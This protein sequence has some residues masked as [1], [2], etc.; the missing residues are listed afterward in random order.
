MRVSQPAAVPHAKRLAC[1][2]PSRR[3]SKSFNKNDTC[4]TMHM[5]C[6]TMHIPCQVTCT[7]RAIYGRHTRSTW[8]RRGLPRRSVAVPSARS[9]RTVATV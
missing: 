5:P 3:D 1:S 6:N 7:V 2:L 8:C 4:N 9:H